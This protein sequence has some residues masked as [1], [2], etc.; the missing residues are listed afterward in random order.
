MWDTGLKMLQAGLSIHLIGIVIY[1]ALCLEF[2][3]AVCRAKNDWS[4][5]FKVL[6]V[7]SKFKYFCIGTCRL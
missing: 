3:I 6:Q 7:S 5:D 2:G 1:A 4:T